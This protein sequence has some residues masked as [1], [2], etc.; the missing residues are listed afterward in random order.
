M[1]PTIAV[2]IPCFNEEARIS[3]VIEDFRQALPLATIYA[4]DNNSTDRTMECARHAGAIVRSEALQGKGHV[5]RRMF[6]DI[7]AVTSVCSLTETA[8][9]MQASRRR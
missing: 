8:P 4:Y 5:V 6:R 3:D 2:L 1:E 7:D 9:T